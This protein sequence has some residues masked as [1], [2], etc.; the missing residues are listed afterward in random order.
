[1]YITLKNVKIWHDVDQCQIS[2]P[3]SWLSPASPE[4]ARTVSQVLDMDDT[5]FWTTSST[6]IFSISALSAEMASVKSNT[7][8]DNNQI[9]KQPSTWYTTYT[10]NYV[11][12]FKKRKNMTWCWSMSN[13]YTFLLVCSCFPGTGPNGITGTRHG[14]H[15]VL[16][17]LL[18]VHFLDLSAVCWDGFC[19]DKFFHI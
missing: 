17:N 18:H 8:I 4:P 12:N 1:M 7:F 19:E 15:G 10:H 11:Y 2:I 9:L 6:S 16:N 3:L 14:R 5:G 13:Q